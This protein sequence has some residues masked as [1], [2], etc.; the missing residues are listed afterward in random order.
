MNTLPPELICAISNYLPIEDFSR[1]LMLNITFYDI[2]KYNLTP[3]LNHCYE[4]N[5]DFAEDEDA[6]NII[7]LENACILSD[8]RIV[9]WL[10]TNGKLINSNKKVNTTPYA[11]R[12]ITMGYGRQFFL[13]KRKKVQYSEQAFLFAVQKGNLRIIEYMMDNDI[14]KRIPIWIPNV[15]CLCGHLDIVEFFHFNNINGF[16]KKSIYKACLSGN[17]ELVDFIICNRLDGVASGTFCAALDKKMYTTIM[18]LNEKR[19]HG[20]I[21]EKTI[22]L[23]YKRAHLDGNEDFVKW[24]INEYGFGHLNATQP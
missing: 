18:K 8:I 1:F 2:L 9:V 21:G 13:E 10:H 22:E 19:V 11:M 12:S 14:I 6:R 15:A 7:A 24:A 4:K 3:L 16:N 20:F 17:E 5:K 23:A